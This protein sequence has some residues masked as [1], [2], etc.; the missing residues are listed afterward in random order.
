MSELV[1]QQDSRKKFSDFCN[2]P[3]SLSPGLVTLES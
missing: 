1:D 3:L 2:S